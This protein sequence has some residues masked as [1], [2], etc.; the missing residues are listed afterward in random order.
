MGHLSDQARKLKEA[1][2]P[3]ELETIQADN[4]FRL[5][6]DRMIRRLRARGVQIP[7]IAEISGISRSQVH[8]I[9]H[10]ADPETDQTA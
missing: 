10:Q 6:R 3:A 5:D 9:T 8:R 1:L 7:V 4:P 2:T